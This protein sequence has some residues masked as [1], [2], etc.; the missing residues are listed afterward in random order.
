MTFQRN[1][2]S[3]TYEMAM[4][5]IE[6]ER[7]TASK[8]CNDDGSRYSPCVLHCPSKTMKLHKSNCEIRLSNA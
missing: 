5:L 1:F 2:I 4:E 7:E 8:A 3:I 6:L